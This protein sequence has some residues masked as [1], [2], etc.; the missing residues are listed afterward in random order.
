MFPK[1]KVTSENT[2]TMEADGDPSTF[3]MSLQLQR[4]DDGIMMKIVKYDLIDP[5][6]VTSST[7]DLY[8]HNHYLEG[9]NDTTSVEDDYGIAAAKGI[10]LKQ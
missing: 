5:S 7:S 1:A 2:I 3:S 9:A 6:N 10:A 4:P 8:Y